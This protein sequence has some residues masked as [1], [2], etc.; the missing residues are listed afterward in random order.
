MTELANYGV[1]VIEQPFS[2]ENPQAAVE[3]RRRLAETG[4][5]ALVLADESATTVD[6]AIATVE[7][8]A[9]DG[10]VV[11]PSRL[12][13]IA[14]TMD[15]VAAADGASSGG[16]RFVV[17]IGGM[18]ESG[19]GRHALAAVAAAASERC[20][21]I[22]GDLSPARRWLEDD[23]W[24]DLDLR[25]T[26]EGCVVAVPDEP[27]VAPEPDPDRLDRYTIKRLTIE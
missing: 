16:G 18:L 13:G 14:P 12:G 19:L 23:P 21:T 15:L 2:T 24:P 10:V 20:G 1:H 27:G 6:A 5:S 11:K 3:L 8:G 4:H 22:T 9:A 17:S 26:A 7:A 25:T